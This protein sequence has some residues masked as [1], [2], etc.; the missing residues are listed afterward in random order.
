MS[1]LVGNP[2]DM[3]SC[4]KAHFIA[5]SLSTFPGINEEHE[6]ILHQE[7]LPTE[8][9]EV[10]EPGPED[11]KLFSC[12]TQLSMK[13]ILHINVNANKLLAF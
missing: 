7:L 12:S 11:I 3:F 4:D 8:L 9:M 13:S 10:T 6:L 1:E 2:E 5:V